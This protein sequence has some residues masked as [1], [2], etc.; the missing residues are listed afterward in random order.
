MP[1]PP[2]NPPPVFAYTDPA[3]RCLHACPARPDGQPGVWLRAD[4]VVL[5]PAVLAELI[6]ALP[7]ISSGFDAPLVAR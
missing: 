7:G 2:P 6:A 1:I 3:G 5:S 4:G